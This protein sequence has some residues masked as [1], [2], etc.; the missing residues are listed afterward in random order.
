MTSHMKGPAVEHGIDHPMKVVIIGGGVGALE[1]ALALHKLGEE[2]I[3]AT[4]IAPEPDFRYRPA[5]VSVPFRRGEVLAFPIADVAE[6]AGARLIHATVAAV[7]VNARTV[8]TSDG[9]Q[10]G[11]D[12]LVVACGARPIPVLEGGIPFRGEEDVPAIE[13]VLEDIE[14]GRASSIVFALPR[15]ASWALP[16]YELA[17]L[18]S[19]H[20]ARRNVTG[21][22]LAVVTPE[23]RPLAQFG[24]EASEAVAALLKSRGITVL[25]ATYPVRV[26]GSVLMLQPLRTLPADRVICMPQARGIVIDG[27][28]HDFEGFL[29]TDLYGR[30]SKAPNVFAIGDV[31]NH[32]IKQGGIAA[33]QADVLAQLLAKAAGAPID[34]PE[35]HRPALHGLLLTGEAPH[36]LTSQPAGGHGAAATIRTEPPWWP[37]GKIAAHHLGAYLAAQARLR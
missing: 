25:T 2:R 19:A 18:T 23:E 15:G 30:V 8:K 26:Y 29:T 36:Y 35:P 17:L 6:A 28:P 7:D 20:I 16:L 9:E 37:G 34:E 21:V 11:Y 33:Q 27:L 13:A 3:G 32:P 4:L 14:S 31:T 1:L 24:G 12:A 5:S 22:S 10:V